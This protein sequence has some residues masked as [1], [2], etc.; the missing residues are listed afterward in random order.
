MVDCFLPSRR[1]R[2]KSLI[3]YSIEKVSLYRRRE[4][5]EAGFVLDI[6]LL[7]WAIVS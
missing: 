3:V 2:S 6:T 7:T 4:D 5:F 1:A